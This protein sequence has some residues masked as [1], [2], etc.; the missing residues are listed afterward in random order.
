MT[1]DDILAQVAV[2]LQCGKRLTRLALKV[3][4]GLDDKH[5][6][7]TAAAGSGVEGY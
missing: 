5:I 6:G 2:S 3:R 4:C 1:F 7:G